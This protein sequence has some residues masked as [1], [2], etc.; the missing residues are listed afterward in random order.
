MT[1]VLAVSE[2]KRLSS[3]NNTTKTIHH[4]HDG[5]T[6]FFITEKQQKNFLKFSLD[7]LNL[8]Y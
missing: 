1:M 6:M 5:E 2:T 4:Y 3:V 8:I 7:S